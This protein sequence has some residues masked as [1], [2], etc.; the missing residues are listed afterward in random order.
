M[1]ISILGGGNMGS[2][3]ATKF[4]Q[5][6]DV[7]L[8][9]RS[10]SVL[11]YSKELILY[12]EDNNIR[13][14]GKISEITNNL[15][16]AIK[17]AEYI[18]IT[19]PAFMFEDLSKE[20]IPLLKNGQHLI[21]VPGSGGAEVVFKEV[22]SKGCTITG[23][24]RVHSV[25]RIM[26]R[27]KSVRESGVRD[28][29]NCASIPREF[30]LKAAVVLSELYSLPVNSLENYL[31]ITLINSN[32]IL[33]TSRLYSI[34]K[35]C[36]ECN[37]YDYLPLFYQDWDLESSDLLIKMDNELFKM[38]DAL[39]ENGIDANQVVPLLKHYDSSNALE[40]TNKLNSINSLKG[41]TT[42]HII[43]SNG[44]LQPDLE[45]RYFTADFPFGLDILLSFA[46]VLKVDVENMEMVSNWYHKL[47][48]SNEC[49]DL[50]RYGINSILNIKK[51]YL[52]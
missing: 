48:N 30:N 3:L 6:H 21:F 32:P 27:G 35:D 36:M 11:E 15:D 12:N 45:S 14:K 2:L 41:L 16:E 33:H 4:S 46:N 44:K 20:L 23:L 52:L 42:P 18:F 51:L 5:S 28:S 50:N 9:V 8:Y 29:I 1:R 31:N 38:F 24:Q 34:F 13:T 37:E 47:I 7:T 10:S 17:D 19:F 49:F 22:I 40:L 39:Y 43:N 26:E 25:A